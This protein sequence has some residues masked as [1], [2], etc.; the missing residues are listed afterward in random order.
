MGDYDGRPESDSG[1]VQRQEGTR[2]TQHAVEMLMLF[3][4][5]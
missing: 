4:A 5:R 2:T 1:S 3:G